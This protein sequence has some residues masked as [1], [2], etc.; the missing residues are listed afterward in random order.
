MRLRRAVEEAK[1][2]KDGHYTIADVTQNMSLLAEALESTCPNWTPRT[3]KTIRELAALLL[4]KV[5]LCK[6]NKNQ[7]KRKRKLQSWLD[8]MDQAQGASQEPPTKR[9]PSASDAKAASK[10][11]SKSQDKKQVAPGNT[12]STLTSGTKTKTPQKGSPH[13]LQ[14]Q[15]TQPRPSNT[16]LP[17]LSSSAASSD[18]VPTQPESCIKVEVS[19]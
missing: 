8:L 17:E 2:A 4:D 5:G 11:S 15:D 14:N 6:S 18:A 19:E 1:G 9:S 13:L 16:V 10:K 3:D 12:S 7:V